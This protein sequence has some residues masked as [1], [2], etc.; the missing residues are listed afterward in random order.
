MKK[1]QGSIVAGAAALVLTLG[2]GCTEEDGTPRV[3][4]QYDG[5]YLGSTNTV[6]LVGEL[7]TT[8]SADLRGS[9]RAVERDG[10]LQITI[11]VTEQD[12]TDEVE[13][14]T[15]RW[16][17]GATGCVSCSGVK[18]TYNH[19]VADDIP[20]CGEGDGSCTVQVQ[21]GEPKKSIEVHFECENV[22]TNVA[23]QMSVRNG[24]MLIE[25]CSGL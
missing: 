9:C 15:L 24:R 14:D 19:T 25:N 3:Q 21:R 5:G 10:Q 4:T 7:G 13:F 18:V 20:C 17:E 2:S 1:Y 23:T 12:N 22:D 11:Q 6:T 16:T 8:H